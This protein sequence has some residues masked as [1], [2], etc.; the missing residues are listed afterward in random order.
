MLS[1]IGTTLTS[2]VSMVLRLNSVKN[3]AKE[4]WNGLFKKY[5]QFPKH[6][7]KPNKQS[8]I[9]QVA[10]SYSLHR[11]R[12]QCNQTKFWLC[13][14]PH[15]SNLM[16]VKLTRILC[17]YQ[18]AYLIFF[19]LC[20]AALNAGQV[21]LALS[22]AITLMGTFQWGVRQSAEVENL[23][24]FISSFSPLGSFSWL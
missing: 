24:T 21:G 14:F 7:R 5:I 16:K 20:S 6:T 12:V 1:Q 19:F 3:P 23:V 22:Y 13:C 10:W 2:C 4:N 18:R 15:V 9:Q 8:K 17:N 11:W